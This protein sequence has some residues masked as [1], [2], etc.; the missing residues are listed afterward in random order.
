MHGNFVASSVC[1]TTVK[2]LSFTAV[3]HTEDAT[4]Y[5]FLEAQGS[6][7]YQFGFE[8]LNWPI[9]AFRP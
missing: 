3:W 8:S 1:Q 9:C 4:T 2:T 7:L 5:F 6:F